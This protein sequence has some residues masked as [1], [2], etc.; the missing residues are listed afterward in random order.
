MS[1]RS[2]R[3]KTGRVALTGAGAALAC[4]AALV[5]APA[6][7]AAPATI[8][9]SLS[10][11]AE[12]TGGNSGDIECGLTTSAVS[13][14]TVS[15][16]ADNYYKIVANYPDDFMVTCG[17]SW[18]PV[19]ITATITDATGSQTSVTTRQMCKTGGPV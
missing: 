3:T 9:A 4:S 6:A 1:L 13:P 12:G 5:A 7:Q 18:Y 19:T 17:S 15:W 8:S 14:F 2:I 10:C 11:F 16:S